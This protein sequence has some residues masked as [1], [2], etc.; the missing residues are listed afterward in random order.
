MKILFIT[1]YFHPEPFS[2]ND[3]AQALVDRG[4]EVEVVCC[5]PNYPDG[6]FYPGYSNNVKR[7]ENWNGIRILRARTIARG[8]SPV[9]LLLNYLAYPVMALVT[10]W[11]RGT[12]FYDVSFTSMPSPI[13]QCVAAFA[14]KVFRGVPAVYWVQDIWPDSLINTIGIN[15]PLLKRGLHILCSFLYRRADIVLVQSQAFMHRLEIMGVPTERI[16][17]FPNTAP[18]DFVPVKRDEVDP[19]IAKL[20][21][22][23]RLRLM[24]A[25]NV[26]ESQNLD[27]IVQAAKHLRSKL[28][29]QWVI[30]GSGRYLERIQNKAT[31]LSVDD[32]VVFVGRHPMASM[33]S[34]YALADAMIISLKDTE[35]FG[36]TVPYKL[37]S[38]MKAGKPVLGSI[39]GETQ[40]I[41]NE[42]GIGFCAD[43]EDLEGFCNAVLNF[44]SQTQEQRSFT[45]E[46]AMRYFDENYASDRIFSKLEQQLIAVANQK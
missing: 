7:E 32:I 18:D 34:F 39:S 11:R 29:I 15:N 2:N 16:A 37:Q 35:I 30:V 24:F 27:L 13:F 19:A 21:P 45:S 26:G 42:A 14:M 33:P 20:L 12:G 38:Y 40:R 28:D 6:V 10:I 5:V 23:A 17:F 44:A 46:I 3:I 8:K 36:L 41:I 9:R 4:N 1:Q 31:E 22:P 43:A 25:G